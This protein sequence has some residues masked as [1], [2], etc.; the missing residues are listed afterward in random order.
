MDIHIVAIDI[1]IVTKAAQAAKNDD[2]AERSSGLENK[3]F[4]ID[5]V[6]FIFL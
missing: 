1:H 5:N 6:F 2:T 3:L 4:S